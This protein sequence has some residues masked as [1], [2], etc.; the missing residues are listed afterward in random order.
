M[1]VEEK[2]RKIFSDCRILA[3]F[4]VWVAVTAGTAGREGVRE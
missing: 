1:E 3:T 2:R 4:L